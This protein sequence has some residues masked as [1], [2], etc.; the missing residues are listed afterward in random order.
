MS[1]R[2]CCIFAGISS[3]YVTGLSFKELCLLKKWRF[4]KEGF[5]EW[6]VRTSLQTKHCGLASAFSS[7]VKVNPIEG[8][9]YYIFEWAVSPVFPLNAKKVRI[10]EIVSG[11][12]A[13]KIH[14]CV[15]NV[16]R[17]LVTFSLC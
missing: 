13:V 5:I 4:N 12:F 6:F 14:K 17:F 9:L 7:I 11:G 3:K 15:K 8:T 1:L 10:C 16:R 2:G